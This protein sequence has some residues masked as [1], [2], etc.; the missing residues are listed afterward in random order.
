M[1]QLKHG[2]YYACLSSTLKYLGFSIFKL[3][4]YPMMVI[5]EMCHAHLN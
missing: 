5:P 4:A 3:R 2:L 1:D